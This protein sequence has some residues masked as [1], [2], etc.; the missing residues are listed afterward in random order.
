MKKVTPFCNTWGISGLLY[1]KKY[2]RNTYKR[3]VIFYAYLYRG[4]VAS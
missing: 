3:S 4:V 1:I 2:D